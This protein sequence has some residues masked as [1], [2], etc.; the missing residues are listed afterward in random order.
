MVDLAGITIKVE[1]IKQSTVIYWAS[2]FQ[3]KLSLH[4]D[5]QKNFSFHRPES[6]FSGFVINVF[7]RKTYAINIQALKRSPIPSQYG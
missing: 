6:T 3:Y 5:I 2:T 7:L 1:T 4:L